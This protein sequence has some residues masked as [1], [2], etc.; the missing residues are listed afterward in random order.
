[1]RVCLKRLQF[2]IVKPDAVFYEHTAD[3]GIS[4]GSSFESQ[5]ACRAQ[6]APALCRALLKMQV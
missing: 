1:M 3:F 2:E 6:Q 4:T 5:E